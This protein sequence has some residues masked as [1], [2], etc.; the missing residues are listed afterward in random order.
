MI[1]FYPSVL[2]GTIKAPASKACALRMMFAA[3]MASTQT[4]IK[5]VPDCADVNTAI[6][7]LTTLGCKITTS[8]EGRLTVTIEPFSKT[9]TL[10]RLDFNFRNSATTARYIMA[11]CSVLGI[12]A[13]CRA[14]NVLARR[15]QASMTS[16]MSLRGENFSSFSLPLE[17]SGRL[18]GGDFLLNG[19][20]GTQSICAL[21][22]ALPLIKEDSNIKLQNP[23]V[24]S[25]FVDMTIDILSKFGVTI[26]KTDF[27][28]HIP[29]QQLFTSPGTLVC[30][31]DWGLASMW[32]TAGS[33]CSLKGGHVVVTDLSEDSLQKYRTA[34]STFSLI[35]QDFKDLNI[36]ASDFPNLA[37]VFAA[38][39]AARGGTIRISGI[40][41]LK[42]K[43]TNRLKSVGNSLSQFGVKCEVTEDGMIIS[44]KED[45][46]YPEDMVIDT[47]GDPWVF[48]SLAVASVAF[49]KPVILKD[50]TGADKIYKDFLKDFKSLGGK[51]EII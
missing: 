18:L 13:N 19:D 32:T 9:A 48:M 11:I 24:D 51:Y 28:Y 21:I 14:E 40:P 1:K 8:G 42:H 5:N 44:G 46:D 35:C 47:M 43:E 29:G 27:G 34:N 45:A 23:L 20:E 33:A 12:P 25:T 49:A 36:D 38:L 17:M 2:N 3:S 6:D 50:E 15:S 30:E 16:M 4:T 10:Q 22:N 41:Q 39:A 37:T 26:E 7:C 31:N